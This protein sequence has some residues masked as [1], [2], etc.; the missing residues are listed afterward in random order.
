VNPPVG[1]QVD[2]LEELRNWWIE[3]GNWKFLP[4]RHKNTKVS[5]RIRKK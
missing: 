1:G 5:V 2:E 4:L 3:I